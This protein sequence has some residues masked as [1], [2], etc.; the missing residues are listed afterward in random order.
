M[1][2]ISKEKIFINIKKSLILENLQNQVLTKSENLVKIKFQ[3]FAT[4]R[5][6]WTRKWIQHEP[7][8]WGRIIWEIILRSIFRRK[9]WK[10]NE[11]WEKLAWRN[12]ICPN[13]G[14]L[15]SIK[16]NKANQ[17][18]IYKVELIKSGKNPKWQR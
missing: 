12:R 7:L 14:K 11:L 3:N 1:N 8:G 13:F 15:F 10:M 9:K 6:V 17:K 5:L 2:I 18:K 16:K 4:L